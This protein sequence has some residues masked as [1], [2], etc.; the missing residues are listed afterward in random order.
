MLATN[1]SSFDDNSTPFSVNTD[2]ISFI[3]HNSAT[4]AICNTK[5]MFIGLF[6]DHTVKQV[7]A[8]RQSTTTK[9]VGTICLILRDNGGTDWSYDIPNIIYE[10]DSPNLTLGIPF[11]GQYF[12]SIT[13][14]SY[15]EDT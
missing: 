12:A 1:L 5:S 7:T 9:R 13:D 11:L 3:I 2:G 6:V 10:P 8:E 14:D 4:G 15:N